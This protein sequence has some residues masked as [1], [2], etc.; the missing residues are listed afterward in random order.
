MSNNTRV[1]ARIDTRPGISG[2]RGL[3]FSLTGSVFGLYVVFGAVP[4][5][6]LALQLS[7]ALGDLRKAAALA[8]ITLLGAIAHMVWQPIVG[9]LSD[10]TRSRWGS[11]TPWVLGGALAAMPF[12]WAMGFTDSIVVLGLLY[13]GS[14]VALTTAEGPISTVIPDRVPLRARG[15][16]SGAR[17]LGVMLG[18]LGGQVFG[19][20]LA[21]NIMVAYVVLSLLP[22]ALV[23]LRL[24]VDPD[25]DNRH[26]PPAPKE[27][28][29]AHI[30]SFRIGFK[31]YPDFWWA[32]ISRVL[33]YIGFFGVY[34]YVLYLFEDYVGLGDQAA[35][36]MTYFGL[37][38]AA[39]VCLIAVPAGLISDRVGRRKLFVVISSVGL[40]VA[41]MIPLFMPTVA[42]MLIMAAVAGAAFGSY[43]AVDVAL[44]TEVLPREDKYGQDF[45]VFTLAGIL[46]QVLAPA[47]AGTIV[48]VTGGYV[49][50]FP[51]ATVFTVLG[52]IAIA[53]IRG[54]R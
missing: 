17:G 10:R 22:V 13:I 38:A 52:A 19:G 2:S 3:F 9:L 14:E 51:I 8:L 7:N 53:P 39:A 34:G 40:G 28:L 11:R 46:P 27:S 15:R 48:L 20:L 47:F 4:S 21:G 42:G 45:G 18:T 33:T 50:L 49:W 6:L 12:L 16:F 35:S 36:K 32:F 25:P 31:R 5:V 41:F 1:T 26:L 44:V 23:A 54:V 37:I 43:Q 24:F 29:L 30:G